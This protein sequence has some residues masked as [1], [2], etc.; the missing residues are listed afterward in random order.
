MKNSYLFLFLVI[1]LITAV[2]VGIAF[3]TPQDNSGT[4]SGPILNLIC[5]KSV[6]AAKN[7][8]DLYWSGPKKDGCGG[9]C[10]SKVCK[11]GNVLNKDTIVP[12][13]N[14][15]TPKIT[16]QD[17]IATAGWQLF[18]INTTQYGLS[19]SKFERDASGNIYAEIGPFSGTIAGV[20]GYAADRGFFSYNKS[21]YDVA[22]PQSPPKK[23]NLRYDNKTYEINIASVDLTN[24]NVIFYL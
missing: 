16:T 8:R 23:I 24:N 15:I 2:L 1:F 20:I 7:E 6:D 4:E 21:L 12:W 14:T 5:R 11:Q 18:V 13:I 22:F 10:Q 19:L 3:Y 9:A 17:Q